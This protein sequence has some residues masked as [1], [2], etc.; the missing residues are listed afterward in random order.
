MR[1]L[2]FSWNLHDINDNEKTSKISV[3]AELNG[4]VSFECCFYLLGRTGPN[5]YIVNVAAL[6]KTK[7]FQRYPFMIS[8][9]FLFIC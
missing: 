6:V 7:P 4:L 5:V 9:F 1:L 8:F 3:S 2:Q